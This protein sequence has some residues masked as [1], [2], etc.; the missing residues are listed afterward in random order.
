[1]TGDYQPPST[2]PKIIALVEQIATWKSQNLMLYTQDIF[3]MLIDHNLIS[4]EEIEEKVRGCKGVAKLPT[5]H[6]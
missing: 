6:F 3:N 5:A 4:K 1:Y 2:D